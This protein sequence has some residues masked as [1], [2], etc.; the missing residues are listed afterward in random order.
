MCTPLAVALMLAYAAP[1]PPLPVLAFQSVAELPRG[2]SP[3]SGRR[4]GR[5]RR[6]RSSRRTRAG[7]GLNHRR[8][9]AVFATVGLYA[10]GS[11][12][13]RR[14][15]GS[16]G[17]GARAA[18]LPCPKGG[19]GSLLRRAGAV[20][21]LEHDRS[22]RHDP[23]LGAGWTIDRQLE[24]PGPVAVPGALGIGLILDIE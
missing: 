4:C 13:S 17:R 16:T 7:M 24:R 6:S 2:S 11:R 9:A 5:R 3:R 8:P 14:S 15:S 23:L 12:S 1:E 19:L 10:S 21:R 18:A 20:A 22:V